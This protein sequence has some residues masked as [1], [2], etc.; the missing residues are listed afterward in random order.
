MIYIIEFFVKLLDVVLD[1]LR[2]RDEQQTIQEYNSAADNPR[3]FFDDGVLNNSDK[4]AS[5]STVSK[6]EPSREPE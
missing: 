5:T 4:Q 2:K 6:T 3:D 1:L